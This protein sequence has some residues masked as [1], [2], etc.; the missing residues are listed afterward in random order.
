[1]GKLASGIAHE[2]GTPLNVVS[3]RAKMIRTSEDLP[4]EPRRNAQIVEQ[5]VER[6]TRII[7]QLLDFARAGDA[8]LVLI[9]WLEV[10]RRVVS[11]LTP[12]AEKRGIASRSRRRRAT[13]RSRVTRVS[14]SRCS[15]TW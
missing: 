10:I 1:M 3:G 5:Q 7:R 9:D 2:L 12:L 14:S 15:R 11:L 8:R 4:E 6:M 13:V